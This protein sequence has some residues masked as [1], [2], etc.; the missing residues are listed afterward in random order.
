MATSFR[1]RK[2]EYLERTTDNEQAIGK[3][4]HLRVR[5]ECTFFSNLQ[6][7]AQTHAI[8]VMGFV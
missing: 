6:S 7:G 3:L 2:P 5:V 1:W 8:L 4:Y